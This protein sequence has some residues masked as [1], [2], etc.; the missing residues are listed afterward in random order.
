MKIRSIP[1][2]M[3]VKIAK[4]KLMHARKHFEDLHKAGLSAEHLI[5]MEKRIKKAD[6]L[7]RIEQ[8]YQNLHYLRERK[9]EVR[10]QSIEYCFIL[11][12]SIIRAFGIDSEQ[13]AAFPHTQ[14]NDG[15]PSDLESVM[16]QVAD[17]LKHNRRALVIGE[18]TAENIEQGV[19]LLKDL[20]GIEDAI[21]TKRTEI[22]RKNKQLAHLGKKLYEDVNVLE[23]VG[24]IAFKDDAGRH[25]LFMR[26]WPQRGSRDKDNGSSYYIPYDLRDKD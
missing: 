14:F 21:H 3:I 17:L 16:I 1:I 20:L 12:D 5:A 4:K 6:S 25:L 10:Q 7:L 8:D 15:D 2:Q 11:R 18:L 22:G 13:Y 26:P 24:D 19:Q 23:E 9:K